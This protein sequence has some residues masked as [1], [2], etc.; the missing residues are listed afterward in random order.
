M[1]SLLAILLEPVFVTDWSKIAMA[2]D[3]VSAGDALTPLHPTL[4]IQ[5]NVGHKELKIIG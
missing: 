5:P 1:A 3:G 2:S 4:P